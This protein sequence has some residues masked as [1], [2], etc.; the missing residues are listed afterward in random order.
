M[1]LGYPRGAFLADRKI[2]LAMDWAAGTNDRLKPKQI[3]ARLDTNRTR[4]V[5]V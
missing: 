3:P 5:C 1:V 4:Y 2:I